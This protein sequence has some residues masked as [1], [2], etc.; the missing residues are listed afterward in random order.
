MNNYSR[1][2]LTD[3][4]LLNGFTSRL[5]LDHNTTAELLAD[6]GE[7]DARGLYL[8]AAYP[9]MREY[10][11][12]EFHMSE[13]VTYKRINAARAARE[14]PA[15]FRA[16]AD[17]RL[18][19]SG[20]LTLAPH[21]TAG[22]VDELLAA[23]AHKTRQQLELLLA[24]RFP[25]P[26]VPTIL[27]ALPTPAVPGTE[28]RRPDTTPLQLAPGQVVTTTGSITE[29]AMVP[30]AAPRTAIVP[31]AAPAKLAPLSPGRFMLQ[32]TVPAATH[33][34]LRRA[35]ELL[36]HAVPS[37]DVAQVL[38]RAL[39]TLIER[40]EKQ[41]FAKTDR[42]QR[43]AR[44]T[45]PERRHI[46]AHVKRAVQERDAGQCTFVS[47]TGRRCAS[48]TRLEYDH[49]EPVARGGE[50][51]V[52]NLRLRCRAHNQ[53]AAEQVYGHDFMRGRRESARERT[54]APPPA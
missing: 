28:S 54:A 46:P 6:I 16:V 2:Q 15:I 5:A 40:L 30:P 29:V 34:K 43:A 8:K 33:D 20:V 4:G 36:G 41:K 31:A 45:S 42:P 35:Q 52:R 37:G 25:K 39:D 12:H 9:S 44:R 21:L 53:F 23:A 32:V 26:D 18:N 24:E 7:I 27:R 17:G 1:A 19:L 50:S 10:C 14:F 11:L 49:I 22:N 51:T 3:Q 47:D 48:R 38:D 13:A